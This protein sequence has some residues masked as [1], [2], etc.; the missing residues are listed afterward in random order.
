MLIKQFKE[1]EKLFS[2]LVKNFVYG[3]TFIVLEDVDID[4]ENTI[5]QLKFRYGIDD[6]CQNNPKFYIELK[7]LSNLEYLRGRFTQYIDERHLESDIW[8]YI[9]EKK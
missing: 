5:V 7:D 1:I 2:K 9:K 8:D 3:N 6:C 4:L